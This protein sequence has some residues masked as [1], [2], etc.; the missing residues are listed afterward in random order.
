MPDASH[1]IRD[2][3]IKALIKMFYMFN[4]LDE[5]NDISLHPVYHVVINNV[6]KHGEVYD[7]EKVEKDINN[8]HSNSTGNLSIEKR[9]EDI[10]SQLKE[11]AIRFYLT[12]EVSDDTSIG[13]TFYKNE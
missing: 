1:R 11:G 2:T 13:Q 4:S 3:T 7:L 10:K 5:R 6:S 8:L 9:I 12:E